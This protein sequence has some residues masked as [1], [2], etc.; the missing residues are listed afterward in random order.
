[1]PEARKPATVT[2]VAS[3]TLPAPAHRG[4]TESNYPF[5]DLE[6]GSAFGVKDRD[7]KGMASA[8]GNANR[9]YRVNKTDDAGN[10]V[11]KTKTMKGTDGV[12]T[13]V[14]DTDNPETV[15]TRHFRVRDVTPEIAKLIKG[16]AL[17]GSKVLVERDK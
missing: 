8:V 7:K 12:E 16:T 10:T 4:G 9:K 11:Y 6:V 15:A 17:E 3:V 14:P 5:D 2:A 1:M 13:Q